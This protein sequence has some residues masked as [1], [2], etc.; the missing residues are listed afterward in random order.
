MRS[1]DQVVGNVFQS[2]FSLVVDILLDGG[3]FPD[4]VIVFGNIKILSVVESVLNHH[5]IVLE[6]Q[7]LEILQSA[8]EICVD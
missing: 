4:L 6:F 7:V 1:K 5:V 3:G 2:G 8:Y